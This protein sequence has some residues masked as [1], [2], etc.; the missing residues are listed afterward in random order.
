MLTDHALVSFKCLKLELIQGRNQA[1]FSSRA[2]SSIGDGGGWAFEAQ[3]PNPLWF[4]RGVASLAEQ[5]H[6][7]GL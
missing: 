6:G 1:L 2:L 7:I 4:V 3:K 5:R